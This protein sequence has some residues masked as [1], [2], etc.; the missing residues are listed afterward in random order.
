MTEKELF[1]TLG[2]GLGGTVDQILALTMSD[3]TDGY[4]SLPVGP[5]HIRC[6]YNLP[7]D[8]RDAIEGRAGQIFKLSREAAV[9]VCGIDDFLPLTMRRYYKETNDIYYPMHLM[10]MDN[11]E[12]ALEIIGVES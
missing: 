1:Y 9:S 4:I 6:T 8:V 5:L 3:V 2:V 10:R 11:E 12:A 7:V